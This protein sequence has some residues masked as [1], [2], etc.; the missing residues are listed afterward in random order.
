MEQNGERN[1]AVPLRQKTNEKCN[2]CNEQK[3]YEL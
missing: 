1:V 3:N 2:Q